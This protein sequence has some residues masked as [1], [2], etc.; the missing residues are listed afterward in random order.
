MMTNF[1]FLGSAATSIRC[2]CKIRQVYRQLSENM[3]TVAADFG[4]THGINV[5]TII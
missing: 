5:P 1:H 2:I 3:L 4:E